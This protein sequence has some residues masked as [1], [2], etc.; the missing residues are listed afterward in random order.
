[1]IIAP[2]INQI[3]LMKNI[4]VII[5]LV[6]L[7][8]C[9][10]SS[11]VVKVP[12]NE[13]VVVDG[14]NYDMSR[15]S[16]K[17]KSLKTVGVAVVNDD[18]EQIR[19]FGLG[20][21]GKADI[22]VESEYKLYIQNKNGDQVTISYDVS[23]ESRAVLELSDNYISFTLRNNSAKSIPLIIPTVMNPNLSPNSNSGVDL[24]IGQQI[25]FKSNGKKYVLLTVDNNIK[26]GDV[27][28]VSELIRVR[29]KELGI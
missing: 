12:A 21:T 3:C 2:L 14:L 29:K 8:A 6:V 20:P 26:G 18:G 11:S 1:M 7:S 28:D 10:T 24:K 23:E 13:R 4:L 27:L 19:G 17:N 9:A 22:M 15:V 25:L 5:I 16:L